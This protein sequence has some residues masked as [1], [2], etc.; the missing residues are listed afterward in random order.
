VLLLDL[1]MDRAT[2]ADIERLAE[3]ASCWSSRR[4]RAED[5]VAALRR[6]ARRGLQAL[7]HRD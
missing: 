1:Q 3:Q 7:R 2:F 5:A 6:R 4:E